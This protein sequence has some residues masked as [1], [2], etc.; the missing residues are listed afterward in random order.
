MKKD[1]WRQ[2]ENS[3]GKVGPDGRGH[4]RAKSKKRKE[5]GEDRI[6]LWLV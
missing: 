4:G 5:K 2:W 3:K 1:E 6:D